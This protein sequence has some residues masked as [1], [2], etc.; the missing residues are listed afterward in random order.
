MALLAT[1]GAVRD[2]EEQPKEGGG[3][4]SDEDEHDSEEDSYDRFQVLVTGV[5]L[6]RLDVDYQ[7]GG[8]AEL[9][10]TD[11]GWLRQAGAPAQD[12]LKVAKLLDFLNDGEVR[13]EI[14]RAAVAIGTTRPM[15]DD[16][17]TR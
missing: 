13:C 8:S 16:A 14:P 10:G 6:R 5:S 4:N 9:E 3:Q 7:P 15:E 12:G 2:H 11:A 17:Q 1:D